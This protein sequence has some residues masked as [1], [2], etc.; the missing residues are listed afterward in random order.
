MKRFVRGA[1]TT[2]TVQTHHIA[3]LVKILHTNTHTEMRSVFSNPNIHTE[4][5]LIANINVCV[6]A[7]RACT[8][9]SSGMLKD[10]ELPGLLVDRL[11]ESHGQVKHEWQ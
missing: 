2:K 9:E 8:S 1:S 10:A 11:G 3:F 6:G 4:M 7:R 5:N